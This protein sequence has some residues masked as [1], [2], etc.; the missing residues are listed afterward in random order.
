MDVYLSIGIR[1]ALLLNPA[2]PRLHRTNDTMRTL[3]LLCLQLLLQQRI[4]HVLRIARTAM[5]NSVGLNA[6]R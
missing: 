2:S 5:V 3:G 1:S 6:Y 4:M